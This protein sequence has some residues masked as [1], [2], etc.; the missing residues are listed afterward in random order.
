M[1]LRM[2]MIAMVLLTTV[3]PAGGATG[4][5]VALAVDLSGESRHGASALHI[6][7]SMLIA[8]GLHVVYRLM[9]SY[10][11]GCDRDL[12]LGFSTAFWQTVLIA[13][14]VIG[15]LFFFALF[16]IVPPINLA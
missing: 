12:V 3:V 5:T 7:V 13:S 10:V 8:L 15:F 9:I 6:F 11:R 16:F 4:L 14:W 2:V 1:R